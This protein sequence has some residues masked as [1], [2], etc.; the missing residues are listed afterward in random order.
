MSGIRSDEIRTGPE[1]ERARSQ[2][3]RDIAELRRHRRVA[4]GELLTLVFENRETIRSLIEE[5]V[6]AER[7]TEG[8]AV[9]QEVAV[10][11]AVVPGPG[12][13]EATLYVEVADPADLASRLEELQGVEEAVYIEVAGR[14]TAGRP[15]QLSLVEEPAPA[16]YVSFELDPQQ[17]E[18][19]LSGAPVSAGVDHPGVRATASLDDEQRRSLAEDLRSAALG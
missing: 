8:V 1:Y 6:R 15:R 2:A 19:W 9:D 7:I 17:R 18:A 16:Y 5:V 13:L 4:L 14:R 11:N 12:E 10:F 3:R